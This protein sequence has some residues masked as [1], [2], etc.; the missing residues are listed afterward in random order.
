MRVLG[1]DIAK[2]SVSACLLTERPAQPREFYYECRFDYLKADA[3]GIRAMLALHP[4]VAIME[5]TGVNYSRLWGTHLA[6]RRS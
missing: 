2:S 6:R 3:S 4:D 5:P 1:L